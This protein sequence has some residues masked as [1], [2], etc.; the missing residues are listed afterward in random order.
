[1]YLPCP[2][3]RRCRIGPRPFLHVGPPRLLSCPIGHRSHACK[4]PSLS[5]DSDCCHMQIHRAAQRPTGDRPGFS[6]ASRTACRWRQFFPAC[7]ILWLR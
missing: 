3:V 7:R 2:M 4:N 1:M 6:P 5:P